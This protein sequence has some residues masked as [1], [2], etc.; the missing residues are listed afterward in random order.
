MISGG[1]Y[2]YKSYCYL[3]WLDH[4]SSVAWLLIY[5]SSPKV[6]GDLGGAG[7]GVEVVGTE[8]LRP[9]RHR[10][11]PCSAFG[12]TQGSS[13]KRGFPWSNR[14]KKD[15]TNGFL[16]VRRLSGGIS[17]SRKNSAPECS[18]TVETACVSSALELPSMERRFGFGSKHTMPNAGRS[19]EIMMSAHGRDRSAWAKSNGVWVFP[20]SAPSDSAW[21]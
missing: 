10:I 9:F 7:Q 13:H 12:G 16:A 21:G 6:P 17:T 2:C 3:R 18:T 20:E 15:A 19:A 1:G 14:Q 5:I 4:T 8:A 11:A